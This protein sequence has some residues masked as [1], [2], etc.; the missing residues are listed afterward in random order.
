MYF[1]TNESGRYS[2]TLSS[3]EISSEHSIYCG[4]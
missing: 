1:V 4:P 2:D 3:D